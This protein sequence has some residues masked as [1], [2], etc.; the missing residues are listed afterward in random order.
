[1]DYSWGVLSLRSLENQLLNFQ[2][3]HDREGLT[4]LDREAIRESTIQR[5]EVADDTSWKIIKRYLSEVLGL[6]DL[7]NSPKPI[8]RIADQNGLLTDIVRWLAYADTRTSTAHDDSGKKAEEALLVI[9]GFVEDAT[10]LYTL[11]SGES[12]T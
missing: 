12:W 1:M 8:L 10:I 3:M 6:P 7:P 4:E 5:F 9:P 2:G 11:L